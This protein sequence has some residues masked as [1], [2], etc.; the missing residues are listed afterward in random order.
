[1]KDS[2]T[3]ILPPD[4]MNPPSD[5]Q[6]PCKDTIQLRVRKVWEDDKEA[7]RPNNIVVHITR[8]YTDASGQEV[9]TRYLTVQTIR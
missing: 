7:N 6:D 2:P 3:H 1:M 8:K 9:R 5:V 4:E